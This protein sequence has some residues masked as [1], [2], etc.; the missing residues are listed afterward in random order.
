MKKDNVIII[1]FYS[2]RVLLSLGAVAS[3]GYLLYKYEY[4][5]QLGAVD[6]I[7]G[8]LPAVLVILSV[9]GFC[10]LLWIKHTKRL[11]ALSISVAA[12]TVLSAV[13]FPNALKGNWWISGKQSSVGA[14]PDI[15]VYA[16]FAENS[17]T[18]KIDGPSELVIYDDFPVLDG[19]LALYPV[20]SAVA[21]SV[22]DRQSFKPESVVFTNTLK[23][24]D[25]IIAGERDIIFTAAASKKQLEKAEK[26]GVD[27][28]FTPIGKEA[29]VFITAKSNPV[30]NL[31]KQQIRNIY[32]GK[33]AKWSTLGWKNGGN[34][35]AFQR[36]EGSGS[37][38]GIQQVMDGFPVQVPQPLPDKSLIGTNSLMQQVTVEW[39]G[40]QPAL[41]YSYRYFANTMFPNP[42]CKLMKIDGIEPCVENIK[43]GEYPFT[44]NFYAVTRGEPQG[45]SKLIIDWLLS[46]QG[47]RLIE[48]CGYTPL[49]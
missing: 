30:D 26:A 11:A 31:N 28:C 1:A 4:F 41:G 36:P 32:S 38:T 46:P 8:A 34:I 25:G 17:K 5:Q 45:N 39:R 10:A 6:N 49:R 35:I 29:F 48:K 12:I 3:G 19:A 15:S 47:Q 43:S 24:Y 37:Q 13:L 22:Y 18:A 7:V 42:D 14:E 20:Y 2:I 33:T 44:V 27:L 16:P 21:E 40:V 9:C 23:A